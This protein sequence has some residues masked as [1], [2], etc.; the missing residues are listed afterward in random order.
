MGDDQLCNVVPTDTIAAFCKNISQLRS[1]DTSILADEYY[2]K[3]SGDANAPFG[4]NSDRFRAEC[5]GVMYDPYDDELQVY[6]MCVSI[7]M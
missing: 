5:E 1:V 6:Y 4:D 3:R 7:Y 2:L